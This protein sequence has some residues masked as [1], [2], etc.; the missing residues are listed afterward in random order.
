MYSQQPNPE[1]RRDPP[2]S[3]IVRRVHSMPFGAEVAADGT[4]RFR[5]WAPAHA[6]VGVEIDG[7]ADVLELERDLAGWHAVTTTRAG[8]GARYRFVLGDGSKIADPASRHQPD[9]VDG[10]SE[11]IDPTAYAWS[12]G[13]WRGQPWA[14]AVIYELHV[15]AFTEEGTFRAAREKLRHLVQ[16]GVTAI[17]LMPIADFP[18]TRN[19][20]YD[21]VMLFAPDSTYG[22]PD[23]LK[24]FVDAAHAHG[25]MVLLDVVYNH[26]GPHGNVLPRCSE[27]V[28]T[29]RHRTPWGDALNFDGADSG[30]LRELVVQNAL[31]W[32]D[33]Y[34]LDGLR[35]DAV[36]AILDDS[37]EHLLVELVRRVREKTRGREIHLVIENENNEAHLLGHSDER[38]VAFDAQWNDD[39]HHVLHIA[40]TGERTG[41][42]ADYHDDP[43]K[44]GRAIAEGFGYQ[45]ETMAFRNAPRGEPSA[46]LPPSAFVSFLQNHDQIGNRAFGERLTQ[47]TSAEKL[48]AV[49]AVQLLLPQVP[50]LFMG[51]EWGAGEPFPF[52]CDFAGELG[53]AVREGR[54][55]E[56]A[57]LPQFANPLERERIPDPQ[58]ESTYESAKLC[59][60]DW[61][62]RHRQHLE[63]YRALLAVRH[64][65]IVPL[66][67]TVVRGGSIRLI[68]SRAVSVEWHSARGALLL[69]ANLSADPIDG[70]TP[71]GDELWREGAVS[72][73]GR[74]GPWSVRWAVREHG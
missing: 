47:L 5:L 26:F 72:A 6:V 39:Q 41:Y 31:Y 2:S 13:A 59:W 8:A 42:Y 65:C 64:R 30:P 19:W 71:Q 43:C 60:T 46:Q 35:L 3:S 29:H 56:F 58:S 48:R 57:R 67:A 49:S 32:L 45:G 12:D 63:R 73:E 14:T 62:T 61:Q 44:L 40:A 17:E 51:E 24:A 25:L 68:A 53:Q 70:E 18:G 23:D 50:L 27:H 21:G 7:V 38:P 15:G 1:A 4:T 33:E 34:H 28:F 54:R 11:V 37:Q 74:Y 9:D 52:F 16:L 69:F 55:R 22:R 10:A 36:H 20:G 66:L